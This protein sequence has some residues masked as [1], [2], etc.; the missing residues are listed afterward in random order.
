MNIQY[1]LTNADLGSFYFFIAIQRN[2]YNFR[3]D[4]MQHSEN[5]LVCFKVETQ[6]KQ[7]YS[8]IILSTYQQS[9]SN[10]EQYNYCD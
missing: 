4:R 10:A 3:N 5:H 6:Y 1:F 8:I 9:S 7:N 2:H